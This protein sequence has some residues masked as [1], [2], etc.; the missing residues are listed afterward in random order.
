MLR[1]T[2]DV[3]AGAADSGLGFQRGEPLDAEIR[4]K[5]YADRQRAAPP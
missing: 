3:C 1:T 4:L 2:P 5:E